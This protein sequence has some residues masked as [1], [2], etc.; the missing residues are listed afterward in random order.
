LPVAFEGQQALRDS[1]GLAVADEV[2]SVVPLDFDD[3]SVWVPAEAAPDE[4]GETIRRLRPRLRRGRALTPSQQRRWRRL[5]V[6]N[7]HDCA[8]MR[9]VCLRATEE[10]DAVA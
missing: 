2:A 6:H 3:W 1:F 4:V 5:L 9:A 7:Q 8:G 10:L